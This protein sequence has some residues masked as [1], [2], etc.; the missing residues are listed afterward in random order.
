MGRYVAVCAIERRFFAALLDALDTDEIDPDDQY[1]TEAWPDHHRTL[2]KLF[3]SRTRD[4]WTQVFKG[5]DACFAPVLTLTEAA[6]HAHSKARQSHLTV[7]GILQPAP[8]PALLPGRRPAFRG[9]PSGPG[10]DAQESLSGWGLGDA[11]IRRL[12]KSGVVEL[13]GLPLA[14]EAVGHLLKRVGVAHDHCHEPS[15]GRL[16]PAGRPAT[17]Q[18]GLPGRPGL[19]RRSPA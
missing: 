13:N 8:A 15:G 19:P 2:E 6:Q 7:D 11:E 3:K 1:N 5:R 17:R 12:I 9:P 14:G 10:E 16:A 4:D 18:A